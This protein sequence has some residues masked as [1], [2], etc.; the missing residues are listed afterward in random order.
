MSLTLVTPPADEPL[1]ASELLEHV[2]ELDPAQAGYLAELG[3]V[4][5]Q[6][7]E[8][9][10]RRALCTQ[11]WRLQLDAFPADQSFLRLPRPPLQAVTSVQYVDQSGTLVT[12]ASSNY[13]VDPDSLPGRLHLAYGVS[14]PSPR[15][16]AN[17][18]RVTYTAGYG[19]AGDAV[20]EALRHALKLLVGAWY[21]HREPLVTGAIATTLPFSV[22]ALLGPFRVLEF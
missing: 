2:R 16:Q 1:T 9:Y 19:D 18:V 5:R 8:D 13:V 14:W 6:H 21:E 22:Q 7:V 3:A 11:T 10:C 4:A 20:P 12:W 15:C 17:A